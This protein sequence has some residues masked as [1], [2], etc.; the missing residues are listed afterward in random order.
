MAIEKQESIVITF[1]TTTAAMAFESKAQAAGVPGR[2]IPVPREISASCGMAWMSRQ[3]A[4]IELNDFLEGAGAALD[5]M[6]R[7]ELML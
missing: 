5:Y 1:P 3:T 7:Y 4:E 2:L 6:G